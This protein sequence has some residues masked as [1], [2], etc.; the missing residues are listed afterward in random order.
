MLVKLTNQVLDIMINDIKEI[1]K[2]SIW[3][4]TNWIDNYILIKY[5]TGDEYKITCN[6]KEEVEKD[7]NII[8]DLLYAKEN[9]LSLSTHA[10]EISKINKLLNEWC[11]SIKVINVNSDEYYSL[12]NMLYAIYELGYKK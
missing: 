3:W 6:S 9:D 7:Y 8:V 4:D 2:K 12:L 5:K 1:Q 11:D 10:E